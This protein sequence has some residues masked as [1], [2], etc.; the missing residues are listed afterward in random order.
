MILGGNRVVLDGVH[1]ILKGG[2]DSIGAIE[3]IQRVYL[4]IGSCA[5][6]C[7]INHLSDLR[8]VDPQHAL[9]ANSF[10]HRSVPARLSNFRA[11][12]T[13]CRSCSRS[14]V[15]GGRCNGPAAARNNERKAKN[16]RPRRIR[17]PI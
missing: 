2:E 4:N 10:Q 15:A 16:R 3:A 14:S 8:Q 12:E 9:R 17:A 6:Q 1:H 7:W 11:I 5:E 13:G